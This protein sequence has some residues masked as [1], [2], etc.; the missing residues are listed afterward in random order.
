[1]II[2]FMCIS[3]ILTGFGLGVLCERIA[4]NK[5]IKDGIIQKPVTRK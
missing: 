2:T 3:L 5:L 4:W 1:M